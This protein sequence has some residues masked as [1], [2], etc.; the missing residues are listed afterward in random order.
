MK[1]SVKVIA[2]GYDEAIVA[3]KAIINN[4]HAT[5]ESTNAHRTIEAT[6]EPVVLIRSI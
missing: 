3:P 2:V 4:H 1:R 5:I 6:R